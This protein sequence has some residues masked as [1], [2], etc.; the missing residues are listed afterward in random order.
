MDGFAINEEYSTFGDNF[1]PNNTFRIMSNL[2]QHNMLCEDCVAV[3]STL[4]LGWMSNH[5]ADD[6]FYFFSGGDTGV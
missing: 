6:F 1:K 5:K 3:T 4:K 2:T